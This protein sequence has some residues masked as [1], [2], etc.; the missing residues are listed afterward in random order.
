MKHDIT[1]AICG[2]CVLR[3]NALRVIHT[4][5]CDLCCCDSCLKHY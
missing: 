3:Y 2:E 4:Q 1:Q 5:N